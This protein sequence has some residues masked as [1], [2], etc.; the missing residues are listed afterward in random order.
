MDIQRKNGEAGLNR[1]DNGGK[2]EEVWYKKVFGV[3]GKALGYINVRPIP[4]LIA[5]AMLLSF[6]NELL[7][8]RSLN[9]TFQFVWERPGMFLLNVLLVFTTLTIPLLFRR[10]MSGVLLISLLWLILGISN[11]VVLSY[12]ITPFSAVDLKLFK[13]VASIVKQYLN[14]VEIILIVAALILVLA[15]A[16]VMWFKAPKIEGK[17]R[18]WPY[19]LIVLASFAS[20][21]GFNELGIHM[22]Q[23]PSNLGNISFVYDACG[24]NYCF[25]S[26]VLDVGIQ[27]PEGY[28]EE[29][30]T[31]I[32]DSLDRTQNGTIT[33]RPNIIIVQLESFYDVNNMKNYSFSENPLPNFT[34]LSENYTSGYITVPSIGAGTANT[35]FE[36]ISG[37]SLDYFGFCEYP[38]KTVLKHTTCESI[39]YDLKGLGYTSVAIHNNRGNF[40]SRNSVFKKLGF[41]NFDSLEYMN[42]LEYNQLGWADDSV[43]TGEIVKAM[44]ATDSP[45][46]IYTIT[47]QSHGA[48]P[49]EGVDGTPR[50][51][52]EGE[53]DAERANKFT[54]FANEIYKTDEF[55]GE[56]V[57]ELSQ[58]DERC[59]VFFFGDHIPTLDITNEELENQTTFQTSYVM[60]D[61]FGLE[62]QDTELYSFQ[63]TSY[64][65]GRL[66]Y[67]NGILTKFHQ[68]C[69]GDSDY[70]DKLELLE[71]DMLYG[72]QYVYHQVNPF[73]ATDMVMGIE[74]ITITKAWERNDNLYVMGENFTDASYV[75]V[76]GDKKE[77]EF[78]QGMYLVVK[79]IDLDDGDSIRV[80]QLA[81]GKSKISKTDEYIYWENPMK[82]TDE[83]VQKN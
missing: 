37:M 55:I 33:T 13:S 6:I 47:V 79:D 63:T 30:M 74:P 60:W 64:I 53:P 38:Y 52:M 48:Y 17:F 21:W 66:G 50:I 35:E 62:K 61:N 1:K 82:E 42:D 31:D 45:D 22:E 16:V 72:E 40:Y 46:F 2:E 9:S 3:I 69:S 73:D 36:T 39:C 26:S 49:A 19:L 41:D 44:E 24:Y 5:I 34:E 77:T 76:N 14:N 58:C 23:I 67:D 81:A 4:I 8:R 70:F 10:R 51:T 68:Q 15:G 57:D 11:Y 56:L 28:S 12:R 71:Y 59:I 54:Y 78:R 25:V 18:R 43:L 29:T 32:V 80:R 65:L 27:K 20:A 83:L 7:T 75:Y